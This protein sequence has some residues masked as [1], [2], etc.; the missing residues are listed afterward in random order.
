MMQLDVHQRQFHSQMPE[1]R[2]SAAPNHLATM[3]ATVRWRWRR[4]WKGQDQESHPRGQRLIND[5]DDE[6]DRKV[7]L[8]SDVSVTS[9]VKITRRLMGSEKN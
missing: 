5:Y 2:P 7:H 1:I 8:I 6:V 3:I 9:V 4:C